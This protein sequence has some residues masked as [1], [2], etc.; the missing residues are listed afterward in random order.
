MTDYAYTVVKDDDE[1]NSVRTVVMETRHGALAIAVSLERRGGLQY[2]VEPVPE[3]E[4]TVEPGRLRP[5]EER[6]A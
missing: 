2:G 1:G 4:L 3:A 5:M 6:C